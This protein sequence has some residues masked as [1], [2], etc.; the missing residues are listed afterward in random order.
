[1]E[2]IVLIIQGEPIDQHAIEFACYIANLTHSHLIGAFIESFEAEEVPVIKAV[3]GSA[4]VETVLASD[5]PGY[6]RIKKSI[7]ENKSLFQQT[8]TRNGVRYSIHE[9]HGDPTEELIKESRY[10]DLIIID[11]ALSG[12]KKSSDI[13]T[14]FFRDSLTRSEC[15]VI[16]APPEFE[17][18]EEV[19]F[20]Y[21]ST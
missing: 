12:I 5:L 21:D 20:L 18:I 19:L 9:N 6:K 7:E 15:S 4:V 16:I 11:P 1:M 8:C 2:K 17:E 3:Y 13:P 14:D 10:A